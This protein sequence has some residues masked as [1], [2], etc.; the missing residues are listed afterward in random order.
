MPEIKQLRRYTNFSNKNR[1]NIKENKPI[2]HSI[3]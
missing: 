2:F 3:R 1:K